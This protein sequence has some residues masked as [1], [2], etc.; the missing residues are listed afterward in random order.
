MIKNPRND[1]STNKSDNHLM[2]TVQRVS[3]IA[4]T[5]NFN[6]VCFATVLYD[7]KAQE[8]DEIDLVK[9]QK[10]QIISKEQED[11]YVLSY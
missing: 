4:G 6:P 5:E 2:S 1:D 3:S 10:I 11:G 8:T 9:G 7:Y